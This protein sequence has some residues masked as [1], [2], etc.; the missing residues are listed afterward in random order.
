M[1]KAVFFSQQQSDMTGLV[2]ELAPKGFQVEGRATGIPDEEKIQLVADAD[3]IMLHGG[4]LSEKILRAANRL[5]FLQ[6]LSAG[7]DNVDLA[8]MRELKIPVANQN[9]AMSRAV[10]EMAIAL[11]L[12]VYRKIVH[13]DNGVRVGKWRH[14]L[15]TGNNTFELTGKTVGIIG[16]GHIGQNVARCLR[17]FDTETLCYDVVSHPDAQRELDVRSVPLDELLSISD[18]VTV[19]VPLIE[20]SR[21]LI[22]ARE[23]SLMKP[24]CVFVNTSRGP[25][26]DETALIDSLKSGGI[27]GAGLD[28]FWSEPIN[29]DNPLIDMDN[30][31][32]TPHCA[33]G[34]YETW[35]RR[36]RFAYENFQRVLK[37]EEP[38]SMVRYE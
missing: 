7:Y 5:Q 17:G 21:Y 38:L 23:L 30:V 19:H 13:L 28:V 31:V 18:V 37:G 6:L 11:M 8:L 20:N 22:G 26:V 15:I 2:V 16:F 35:P 10:A 34:T 25:V 12:A 14:D 33:G 3:F 29:P 4:R 36:V 32:L 27:M 24:S 1:V 9:E